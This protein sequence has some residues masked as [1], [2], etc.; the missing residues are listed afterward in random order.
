M[1]TTPS[2]AE[3]P[4]I[5]ISRCY[6]IVFTVLLLGIPVIAVALRASESMREPQPVQVAIP[7]T[8][9]TADIAI[10][11]GRGRTASTVDNRL[12]L[13]VAYMN[14]KEPEQAIPILLSLVAD[15]K[16]NATA[17]NNLCVAHN[18]QK[19]YKDGVTAC[20]KAL[21][22][23]PRFQ[24]AANNLKWAVDEQKKDEQQIAAAFP[25][26][27]AK[28]SSQSPEAAFYLTQG[29]HQLNSGD[30]DAA[31]DS[32][33]RILA[34]DP[35][36]ALA[37]NNI[38]TAYMFKKEPAIALKWFQRAVKSAP[39]LQIARNNIAWATGEQAKTGH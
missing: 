5:P 13:S 6:A 29:L 26:S 33:R 34:L 15:D 35:S 8:P 14:A 2:T 36:N 17:W 20:R 7:E 38:G 28:T 16:N 27:Q 1:T 22:I 25:L 4:S 19:D 11:E 9:R 31:I 30:Y 24:L 3:I 32:W 12:S 37:A 21:D 18:L 10:L 39:S 23:D